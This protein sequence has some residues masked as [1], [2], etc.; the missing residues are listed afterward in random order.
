MDINY[1]DQTYKEFL[2]EL[3]EKERQTNV[4]S[5]LSKRAFGYKVVEGITAKSVFTPAFGCLGNAQS[6]KIGKDSVKGK[7]ELWSSEK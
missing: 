3:R 2:N 6:K 7:K 4:Q 1:E 5:L